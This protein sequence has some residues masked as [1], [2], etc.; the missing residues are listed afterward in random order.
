M[1]PSEE[2]CCRPDE[3]KTESGE[4][5]QT[6]KNELTGKAPKGDGWGMNYVRKCLPREDKVWVREGREGKEKLF[7]LVKR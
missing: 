7:T 6:C 4:I 1:F 3:A 2:N 5:S